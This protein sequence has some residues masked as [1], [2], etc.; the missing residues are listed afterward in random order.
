MSHFGTSSGIGMLIFARLGHPHGAVLLPAPHGPRNLVSVVGNGPH[1]R[2]PCRCVT[3][4]QPAPCTKGDHPK[5]WATGPPTIH[6]HTP[7]M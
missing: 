4:A 2:S 3:A 1:H 5:V 7:P 6:H